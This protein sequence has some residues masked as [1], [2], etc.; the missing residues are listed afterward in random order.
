VERHGGWL[1]CRSEPGKGTVFT[2][3]LP[4]RHQPG[5]D[6]GLAQRTRVLL[7]ERDPD[8]RRLTGV[9]LAHGGYEPILCGSLEEARRQ[10]ERPSAAI[11]VLLLDAELCARRG[12]DE[13]R[14]LQG[15]LP[16]AA[17]VYLTTGQAMSGRSAKQGVVTKPFRA[18][19]LLEAIRVTL[20]AARIG[21]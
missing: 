19:Q 3:E 7:V 12:E 20:G 11:R 4:V 2:L 18:E 10:A 16:G 17:V 14:R 6:P 9:I 13:Q 15:M 21:V 5:S 1:S 8:I